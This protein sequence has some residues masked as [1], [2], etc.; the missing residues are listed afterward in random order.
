[1][2]ILHYFYSGNVF[3]LSIYSSNRMHFIIH[4]FQS[5]YDNRVDLNEVTVNNFICSENN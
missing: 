5:T 1:M 2:I 3:N 4:F